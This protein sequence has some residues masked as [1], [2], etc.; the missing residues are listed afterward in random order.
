MFII[1]FGSSSTQYKYSNFVKTQDK[2]LL[3]QFKDMLQIKISRNNESLQTIFQQQ[4]RDYH[5]KAL[6]IWAYT[7]VPKPL[8]TKSDDHK[9]A[10]T[11]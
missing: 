10:D 9:P 6:I 2:Y 4:D 8:R 1:I 7:A 11:Q 3:T 5:H